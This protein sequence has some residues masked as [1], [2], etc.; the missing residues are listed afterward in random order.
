[1]PV[2]SAARFR[3]GDAIRLGP[4]N[5]EVPNH[6]YAET[7]DV[8]AV[9]RLSEREAVEFLAIRSLGSFDLGNQRRGSSWARSAVTLRQAASSGRK[10]FPTRYVLI[11][12]TSYL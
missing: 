6:G 5:L 1:M 12:D 4:V 8:E 10:C 11:K 2:F 9:H 3:I 7:G